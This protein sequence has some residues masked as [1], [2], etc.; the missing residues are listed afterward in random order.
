[1]IVVS[2]EDDDYDDDEKNVVHSYYIHLINRITGLLYKIN[3]S[4]RNQYDLFESVLLVVDINF[5]LDSSFIHHTTATLSTHTYI[6]SR[7]RRFSFVLIFLAIYSHLLR[8]LKWLLCIQ[9][10]IGLLC[11]IKQK[12]KSSL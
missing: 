1:M 10:E 8:L 7:R 2:E 11:I 3:E 9:F 12:K 6:L 4:R 5:F